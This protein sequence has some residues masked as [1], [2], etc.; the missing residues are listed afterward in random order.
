MNNFYYN[1][2][3]SKFG[4]ENLNLLAMD[5]D[6]LMLEIQNKDLFQFESS[7]NQTIE[8]IGFHIKLYTYV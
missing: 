8:F 7:N 2:L 5:T 4:K 1:K 3:I 6:S